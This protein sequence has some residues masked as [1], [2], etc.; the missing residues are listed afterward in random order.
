MHTPL[1]G[2]C[3]LANCAFCTAL[4]SYLAPEHNPHASARTA[5]GFDNSTE[6][7]T[8]PLELTPFGSIKSELY[9]GQDSSTIFPTL[10]PE[11]PS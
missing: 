10:V 11:A 7:P 5:D 6:E 9:T 1:D 8:H 2:S 4:H 3:L